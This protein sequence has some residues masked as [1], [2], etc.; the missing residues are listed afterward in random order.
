[1]KWLV[2]VM[3]L[4]GLVKFQEL[5]MGVANVWEVGVWVV[6]QGM[7]HMWC[8]LCC[9]NQREEGLVILLLPEL[10]SWLGSLH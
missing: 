4:M 3:G 8:W 7:I 2:M 1:M 6:G 5:V 9:I 10:Q